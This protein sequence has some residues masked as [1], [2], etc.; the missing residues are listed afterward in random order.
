MRRRVSNRGYNHLRRAGDVLVAGAVSAVIPGMGS[1]IKTG[2]TSAKVVASSTRATTT[3]AQQSA[4]TANRAAKLEQRIAAHS[5][6]INAAKREAADAAGV[7]TVH[8]IV[9]EMGQEVAPPVTP[10]VADASAS[11]TP[12]PTPPPLPPCT[13]SGHSGDGCAR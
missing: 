8:Q 6:K 11:G 3:L 9:K 1:A 2:V 7:A 12:E 4:R 5:D 10:A 13:T